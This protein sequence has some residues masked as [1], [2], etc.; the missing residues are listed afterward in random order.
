MRPDPKTSDATETIDALL[1]RYVAGSLPAPAR[2]L[3]ES[4]LQLK[5]DNRGLT[6]GLEAMAGVELDAGV[7]V[8]LGSPE[9]RIDAIVTGETAPDA[10]VRETTAAG[11]FPPALRDFVGFDVE[12]VPWRTKMPGFKEYD[13][14]E[15]DGCHVSLFWIRPGRKIPAHTHEGTEL[16]LVL[17]GAFTDRTGRYGRGDISLADDTIDHRPTA[18]KDRPCIGLAVTDGPLRLTGPLHQRLSDILGV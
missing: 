1:A 6:A 2:V 17:D 10:P 11:I 13:I 7:P 18:E 12:D 3:V 5:P 15:I 14:G 8:A 16:S 4:H 9:K